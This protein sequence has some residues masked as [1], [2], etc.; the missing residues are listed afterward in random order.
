MSL[1]GHRLEERGLFST[2]IL[3]LRDI[4]S[5][6]YCPVTLSPHCA[7]PA[8]LWR[9]PGAFFVRRLK[10]T[11]NKM[12][13]LRDINSAGYLSRQGHDIGKKIASQTSLFCPVRDNMIQ[14]I[15]HILHQCYVPNGTQV[16]GE[17]IVFYQYSVPTGHQ[18]GRLLSRYFIFPLCRPC[19]T[20]LLNPVRL[21][22]HYH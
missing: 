3:S 6:G 22:D 19:G 7:V 14:D 11:V 10:S 15:Q 18:F 21:N 5:A 17:G 2:N 9:E 4:N 1:T 13:S 8:G 16:G 20:L 12:P